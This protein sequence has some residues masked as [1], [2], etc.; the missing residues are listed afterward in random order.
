MVEA[1]VALVKQAVASDSRMSYRTGAGTRAVA[2]RLMHGGSRE[3][4]NRGCV[5]SK[6]VP[7]SESGTGNGT[8]LSLS[9]SSDC[10]LAVPTP[11]VAK[12][13]WGYCYVSRTGTGTA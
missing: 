4:G 7:D 13:R 6:L 11:T 3:R 1:A 5:T 10:H 12:R 9:I 2:S 8:S